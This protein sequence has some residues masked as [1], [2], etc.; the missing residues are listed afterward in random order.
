MVLLRDI[1]N[2]ELKPEEII[3]IDSSDNTNH[4]YLIIANYLKKTNIKFKLIQRT[5]AY[6]GAARN[7]GVKAACGDLLAFLDVKT[8]PKKDW[9]NSTNTLL[10]N[11]P[12]VYGILGA[13]QYISNR[14]FSK[15]VKLAT[16]G[17]SPIQTLPGSLLKRNTMNIT[18]QFIEFTRAGE[19]ADWMKR[20]HLHKL[21]ILNGISIIHY[22]GLDGLSFSAIL[23][24]WY[25]N[26]KH[27]AKLPYLNA[28]KSLYYHALMVLMLIIAFNWN[29]VVASWN[30]E[31][32]LYIPNFT[33][34][35]FF[36]LL[37]AYFCIR[38]IWFPFKK[39]ANFFDLLPWNWIFISIISIFLDFTKALAFVRV[40]WKND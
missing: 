32:G 8:V 19:D 6:P 12:N 40:K 9:L 1:D 18:G 14:F 29:W 27:A 26:Y 5:R 16:Y 37:I 39:G 7:I 20:L 21:N 38:G 13:T 2:W 17:E 28:H 30:I 33:K 31:S 4:S 36:I 22:D 23:G 11:N 15:M 34:I 10:S 25:R 24:K 35:V 3:I